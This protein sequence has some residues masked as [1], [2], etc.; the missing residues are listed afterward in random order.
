MPT[1]LRKEPDNSMEFEH[2]FVTEIC[3]AIENEI[4]RSWPDVK[5]EP[6]IF[7]KM[8]NSAETKKIK[9]VQQQLRKLSEILKRGVPRLAVQ[10]GPM[11]KRI[12]RRKS[13]QMEISLVHPSK[14]TF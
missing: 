4:T 11:H 5:N 14:L 6:G 8:F 10:Y 9:D 7:A 12:N 3:E 13:I 2:I 1:D